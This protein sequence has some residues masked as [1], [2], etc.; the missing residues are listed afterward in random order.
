MSPA[1]ARTSRGAIVAAGR[2]IL[3]ESGLEGVTMASVAQRVGV[4]P[5]SLYKHVADRSGLLAAIAADAAAELGRILTAAA[6]A[7]PGDGPAVPGTA[8]RDA[9]AR[10]AGTAGQD[11]NGTTQPEG[12]GTAER[13]LEPAMA[14]IV[15]LADAYRTFAGRKPRAAAM[16]FADLSVEARP[17][18]EAAA[19]AA[20]PVLD[21]AAALAGSTRGLAA[22]RVLTAFAYGFTSMEAA[23]A[24]RFGGDVDEAFR[25]GVTAI[26]H[27]L[28]SP[29][30]GG[31]AG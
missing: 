3:E 6:A 28:A 19:A 1:P 10:A 4:K 11:P 21:A 14:R 29:D 12:S 15:A 31:A 2:A 20:R 26:A 9:A 13:A 25:L 16:L 22:A 18:V 30:T 17:P 24:F 23:G 7:G 8:G 27:G 5:P